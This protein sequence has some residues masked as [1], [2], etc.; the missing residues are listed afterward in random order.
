MEEAVLK[1]LSLRVRILLFFAA[2]AAG[3]VVALAVGLWFGYHRQGAPEMLNAF[4]QGGVAA[5][6]AM[7]GLITWV[8]YL[9]DTHLARPMQGL[10]G[11]ILA[12][13]HADVA[14]D[15]NPE[16]ARYLGEL[17]TAASAAAVTLT[18]TRSALTESV[19]RET[20][21]LSADKGKL[22]DL[23]ADVPP[24]VL[25]C[26]G[27]HHLVFYNSAAVQLLSDEKRPVCLDKSLFDYLD[28]STIRQAHHRLLETGHRSAMELLCTTPSGHRRLAARMRLVGDAG[29]DPGAYVMTLRDVSAE[30]SSYARRDA[31]LAEVFEQFLPTLKASAS[32][33]GSPGFADLLSK[34]ADL[35][36]RYA[37]CRSDTWPMTLIDAAL[38]SRDLR[39][40]LAEMAPEFG[41][42]WG[43]YAVR[44]NSFDMV[45]L[46]RHVTER[47]VRECSAQDLFLTFVPEEKGAQLRLSWRGGR[48]SDERLGE[49]LAEPLDGTGGGLTGLAVVAG[50]GASLFRGQV[51]PDEC[52]VLRLPE[53]ERREV[54][55]HGNDRFVVY[56]FDLLS[57]LQYDRISEAR[58][59]DLT[60]VVFDTE[61]TGLLP[62]Q[63]DEIV[64]I[65]AVRVV[66]GKRVQGEVF[67]TLVNPGR[68][69][70][71]A[72]T[73]VHGVSDAMVADAPPV[74]EVIERFHKF[75]EG[76]VLVAHNAPFDMEFLRR[77][78]REVGIH[79][80]NPILDTVL[81]SAVVF[82]Q[83]E[84]HSLDALS[85]RLGITIADED[86]HTALGDT[87][88]TADAFIKLKSMMQAKGIE[89]F[90][91]VLTE[92]RRHG[93]L[94]R[95]LN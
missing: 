20:A 62:E 64:Q 76:S 90:G 1:K 77:R 78:E 10:A 94:L 56:D 95:D 29:D 31:L 66:N 46:I 55:R 19:A 70:P 41:G 87:I 15:L 48:I 28:D 33:A 24:G 68:P 27:R 82:G 2:L 79:F 44:C 11:A 80:A 73:A 85:Q 91:E 12:R 45:A 47:V 52:V 23:L 5:A 60:Y 88:A 34:A 36:D 72:S 83:S 58:L 74:R 51:P 61:T 89:R 6:F 50:H 84:T 25:L 67:D 40:S 18:R 49:W 81:L 39:S 69:I 13:T 9:F 26:T 3:S 53:A 30:L 54:S 65:A 38:I 22:E 92:V 93:R 8:W 71:A 32:D 86:R 43:A 37:I 7:V 21:R 59:D 35:E 14:E 17:A 16:S 63:G 4:I 75:A 57:R 42:P